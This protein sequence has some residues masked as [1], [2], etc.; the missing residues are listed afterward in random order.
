M[1]GAKTKLFDGT[2][3]R[4]SLWCS[5]DSVVFR[6]FDFGASSKGFASLRMTADERRSLG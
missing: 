6:G 3:E 4:T 2:V 1:N 5:V